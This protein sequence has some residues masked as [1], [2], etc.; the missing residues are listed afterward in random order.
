MQQW[1]I[2]KPVY[3]TGGFCI[4]LMLLGLSES[5]NYHS[6]WIHIQFR[7]YCLVSD[8]ILI[9]T[10]INS[11]RVLVLLWAS[12][13]AEQMSGDNDHRLAWQWKHSFLFPLNWD[14][15]KKKSFAKGCTLVCKYFSYIG[16]KVN[17]ST[18]RECVRKAIWEKKK[19]RST[20]S[21]W[22]STMAKENVLVVF[23]QIYKCF[24]C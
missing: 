9:I 14:K 15:R 6:R 22:S 10:I 18:E 1:F 23:Q 8:K 7:L 12:I 20:C 19:V 17:P 3:S 2:R 4:Q 21:T 16:W 24:F 13:T 5:L 11:Q